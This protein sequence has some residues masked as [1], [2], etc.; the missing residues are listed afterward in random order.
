[1]MLVEITRVR[2]LMDISFMIAS[3]SNVLMKISVANCIV[4]LHALLADLD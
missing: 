1:M 3:D 2:Q 4:R